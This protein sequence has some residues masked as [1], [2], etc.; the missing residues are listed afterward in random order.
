[1]KSLKKMANNTRQ[2]GFSQFLKFGIV[3]ISNTLVSLMVYY[4]L[5]HLS[6]H[7]IIANTMGFIAGVLN[8]YYWNNRYVFEK[9]KNISAMSV[10][11]KV[12]IVYGL[13]FILNTGFLFIMVN[14][15]NISIYVAP[16]INVCIL[17]PFN[18]LLNKYWAFG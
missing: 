8:A 12:F 3:G 7:Y 18:F 4:F 15:L 5:I 9:K 13:T 16:I 2:N 14:F 11:A 1:M 10:L 6:V 17:T